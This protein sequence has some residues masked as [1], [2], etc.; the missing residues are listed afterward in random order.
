VKWSDLA[1]PAPTA[2]ESTTETGDVEVTDLTVLVSAVKEAAE[3]M[4]AR[5]QPSP[6]LPALPTGLTLSEL[7]RGRPPA[8]EPGRIRPAPVGLI[9][10]PS[11]Q[12]QFPY[13]L[14]LAK[15]GHLHVMG[16]G[17]SG[18][19]QTLRTIAASLALAHHPTDVHMY[20]LD[21]GNG[22]LLPLERLA[23]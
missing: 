4:G 15:T 12:R 18:R 9:D 8:A 6:W 17:R 1:L 2:A 3:R 21:C 5:R 19:S 7:L 10:V 11:Q 23:A 20:G 14:D 13:T 16:S 22:A